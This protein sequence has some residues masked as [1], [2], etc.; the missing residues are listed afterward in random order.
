MGWLTPPVL[1][2]KMREVVRVKRKPLCPLAL[3]WEGPYPFLRKGM[4]FYGLVLP[5]QG[6]IG[7]RGT[8]RCGVGLIPPPPGEFP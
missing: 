3:W 4:G 2:Q 5:G 7:V 8:E 1:R 6:F